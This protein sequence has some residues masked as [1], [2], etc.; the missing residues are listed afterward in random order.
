MNNPLLTTLEIVQ[1]LGVQSAS[2]SELMTKFSIS[3]ASLKRHL[4]EARLLGANIESIR[5]GK[6][7]VYVLANKDAVR[8]KVHQWIQLERERDLTGF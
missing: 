3:V 1:M 6:G 2:A 7:W 8:T 4:F 5:F